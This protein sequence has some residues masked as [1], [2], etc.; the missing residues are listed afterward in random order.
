MALCSQRRAV[1]HSRFT[2][3]GEILSTR[4]VSSMESPPK[5]RSS[6]IWPWRASSAARPVRASSKASTSNSFFLEGDCVIEHQGDGVASS[7]GGAVHAGV[8][9]QNPAHH[10][11]RYCKEM[12][13]IL[14][15]NVAATHQPQIG[16]MHESRYFA[17]SDREAGWRGID[18]PP[19][20]VRR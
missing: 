8:V 6:T 15:V 18:A 5:K 13:A 16:L 14:P 17:G 2:V 3:A 7:F 11:S 20:G 12:D 4:D 10:A 19:G 1:A 9:N